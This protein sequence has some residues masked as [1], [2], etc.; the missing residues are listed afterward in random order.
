ME[1]IVPFVKYVF[2]IAFG[3]EILL[4]LRALFQLARD[5]AGD[6]QAPAPAVEE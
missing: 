2:V 6:G 1:S 5:K 3:V 4:I